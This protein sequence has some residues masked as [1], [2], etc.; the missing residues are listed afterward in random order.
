[1]S[2]ETMKTAVVMESKG[3]KT[4]MVIGQIIHAVFAVIVGSIFISYLVNVNDMQDAWI[5]SC[6][7][8]TTKLEKEEC[9]T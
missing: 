9:I 5:K 7:V 3:K 4:C 2:M 6:D 8:L 1:M